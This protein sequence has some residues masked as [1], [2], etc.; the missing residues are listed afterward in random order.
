VLEKLITFDADAAEL[1]EGDAE[2]D[3]DDEENGP[4]IAVNFMRPKMVERR[5]AISSCVD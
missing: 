3:T 5:R 2:P 4:P 1:E